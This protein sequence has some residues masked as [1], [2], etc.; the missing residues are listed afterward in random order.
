MFKVERKEL[1]ERKGP[2]LKEIMAKAKRQRYHGGCSQR[3]GEELDLERSGE[4]AR[5]W[6]ES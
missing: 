1:V 6:Q 2:K 5:H 4:S 3:M